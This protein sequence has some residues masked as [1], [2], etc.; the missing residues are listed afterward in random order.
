[1]RTDFLAVKTMLKHIPFGKHLGLIYD[2]LVLFL[3]ETNCYDSILFRFLRLFVVKEFLFTI[4]IE[5]VILIFRLCFV[6]LAKY[7][8]LTFA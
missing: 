6:V 7:K 1:M 8:V 5:T 4:I 3:S 2:Y